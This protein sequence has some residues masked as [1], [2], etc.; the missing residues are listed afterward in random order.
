MGQTIAVSDLEARKVRVL[1]A[2]R[3]LSGEDIPVLDEDERWLLDEFRDVR[4]WG[5]GRVEVI[6]VK[7]RIDGINPTKHK[8]R[9]DLINSFQTT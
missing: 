6:L 1:L 3:L 7:H 4:D 8:K 9:R 2:L 5:Y